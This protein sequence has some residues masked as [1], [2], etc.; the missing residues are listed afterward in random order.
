M[1][2]VFYNIY[3]VSKIFFI[4]LFIV[5]STSSVIQADNPKVDLNVNSI[6]DSYNAYG[7]VSIDVN[8]EN[9]ND[10]DY[11]YE[12]KRSSDYLYWQN[13]GL[14]FNYNNKYK[15]IC[16]QK[17]SVLNVYPDNDSFSIS[18]ELKKEYSNE[19]IENMKK[20]YSVP[21]GTYTYLNNNSVNLPRSA[22]L[23]IWMEGGTYREGSDLY[24]YNDLSYYNGEKMIEVTPMSMKEFNS[25]STLKS[26]L[27]NFD[28]VFFGTWDA[29]AWNDL[30]Q[31]AYKTVKE[32]I[33]SGNG[34]IFGHDTIAY[35]ILP[36]GVF[37]GRFEHEN[38]C[39]LYSL[40]G[41]KTIPKKYA[42]ASLIKKNANGLT[43]PLKYQIWGGNEKNDSVA[44]K[45]SK[46]KRAEDC[47][48]TTFPY[49]LLGVNGKPRI[50]NV[51]QTHTSWMGLLSEKNNIVS[52]VNNDYSI[53]PDN[54]R[55]AYGK[56][57][58]LSYNWYLGSVS[59]SYACYSIQTGHKR[60]KSLEDE[61]K[62]IA[63]VLCSSYRTE[64]IGSIGTSGKTKVDTSAQDKAAPKV[65]KPEIIVNGDNKYKII[66]SGEDEGSLYFYYCML[67]SPTGVYLAQSDDKSIKVTT[68]I[69][70][71][72]YI[73]D[74]RADN[75]DFNIESSNRV[76][77][78]EN[79][80]GIDVSVKNISN[81]FLHI[82]AMD[83]AG[84]V[85]SPI[86]IDLKEEI[87][88][89]LYPV[90]VKTNEK[91]YLY[92]AQ[93][94]AGIRHYYVNS[95]SEFTLEGG[96]FISPIAT[97]SMQP[98]QNY[99]GSYCIVTKLDEKIGENKYTF[100]ENKKYNSLIKILTE[101]QV[102]SDKSRKLT[103]SVKA[104]FEN[105]SEG[106]SNY[107][108]PAGII[109]KNGK[110]ERVSSGLKDQIII[111]CDGRGPEV[112]YENY[113]IWY[114]S[115]DY[116]KPFRLNII[117]KDSGSG[118]KKCDITLKK[119]EN[120]QWYILDK[121]S[122]SK[123][124]NIYDFFSYAKE[125]QF[126]YILNAYDNVDN[127]TSVKITFGVDKTAPEV[128]N[129]QECYGWTNQNVNIN[130]VGKDDLSGVKSMQLCDEYGNIIKIVSG[131]NIQYTFTE[132]QD[133]KY[134]VVAEDIAGNV[135]EKYCF[136][137]KIDKSKPEISAEGLSDE[138]KTEEGG[139][140]FFYLPINSLNITAKDKNENG[141]CSGIE[142]LTLKNDK[143]Q[144]IL[145]VE[146]DKEKIK[147]NSQLMMFYE[148]INAQKSDFYSII[149]VDSAKNVRKIYVVP[150]ICMTNRIRRF[151]LHENFDEKYGYYRVYE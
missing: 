110:Y 121:K 99:L 48:L 7:G 2:C 9:V 119:N 91:R 145:R 97:A 70:D 102:R 93:D 92:Q 19:T 37:S 112:K 100:N 29:N 26:K 73:I 44:V 68:G 116:L 90:E 47:S 142:T 63:N 114:N 129:V 71:Y 43:L 105:G 137:V 109:F 151:V 83:F 35:E 31:S 144:V 25:L 128:N 23:K 56:Q 42:G 108:N 117:C 80:T 20:I 136:N 22:S 123:E 11:I 33:E 49:D 13:I 82:K 85:S 15:K 148:V 59:S 107:I 106:K 127:I 104:K 84:N 134:F 75:Y 14:G 34:V 146:N 41:F 77:D 30:S 135:S 122:D 76:I 130:F 98:Y 50:L 55:N 28:T 52:F 150:Q 140:E 4:C 61:R 54:T 124:T 143:N 58:E 72:Y 78:S 38:M 6:S 62:L 5:M 16:P 12:I 96:C 17:I 1:R 45:F 95:N 115:E 81:S 125:G 40:A 149:A 94:K 139:N 101:K 103:Y 147:Q 74:N 10:V 39:K 32:Y 118:L 88:S 131:S 21:S 67:Y 18:E 86:V 133:K 65:Y 141:I 87:I 60:N 51:P 113:K 132:Q 138:K 111:S 8:F 24:T 79:K 126:Q 3:G 53:L 64:K 66:F 46:S 27:S 89:G 57:P 69:K 120:N 36:Q